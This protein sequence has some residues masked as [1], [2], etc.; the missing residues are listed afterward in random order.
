MAVGDDL[1]APGAQGESASEQLVEADAGGVGDDHLAGSR[2]QGGFAEG[3]ADSL[4]QF[5]PAFGPGADEP[6]APLP[7]EQ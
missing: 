7:G 6:G 3:V 2:A 4:G 5:H 1:V